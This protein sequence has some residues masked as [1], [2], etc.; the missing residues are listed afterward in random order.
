LTTE[1]L[2]AYYGDDFTGSTDALEALAGAGL[3]TVLF[4]E[5]PTPA[6]L[7]RFPGLHA[8]GL[9]GTSRAMTPPEMDRALPDAFRHLR[10]LGA[11]IL[12]YKVCSTFDSSPQIGSIGHA[13]ALGQ[14]VCASPV[15]P[16]LVGA[17]ALGRYCVFG[18]LFARSGLDSEPYRLDRHPTMAHHPTTPMAES[19]LR[20]HLACQTS[21]PVALLDLL[22]LTD[23][24]AAAQR[25]AALRP[26]HG[27]VLFDVLSDDQLPIIGRLIAA[28]SRRTPPLFVLGSSGVEYA[29]TAY[30][31]QAGVLPPPPTFAPLLPVDQLI[32]VSG[33]C[34]PVTDR[35][36]AWALEHGFSEVALAT[37]QLVD[38]ATAAPA[39]NAACRRGLD[40]LAAGRSV[41]VHTCRGPAD[42]R[43]ERTL[44]GLTAQGLDP[45][46]AKAALPHLLG[47]ALG[48]ILG[49]LLTASGL[50]RA[51]IAGGD[52][53]GPVARALGL[54]ALE[55]RSPLAP[56]SPLCRATA[57]GS[58]LDGLE[59]VFK[60]GQVGHPDFF[61]NVRDREKQL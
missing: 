31:R 61:T 60:G 29:L 52:T 13:M 4:L 33:T 22:A 7:A 18:N 43:R 6:A 21:L 1:L 19:D 48:Q 46:Q 59:V 39:V 40:L 10:D 11:P 51:V 50:R 42:A 17:P 26:A 37:D 8:V 56:G 47:T 15:V 2:L 23:A 55:M 45:L 14:A 25:Y 16:L 58:P 49:S 36:I 20:R 27:A 32:A 28:E 54:T 3:R 12:H 9:A 53:S 5:P 44:D 41:V 35:Q 30:W 57:P 38:P 34:S 24:T